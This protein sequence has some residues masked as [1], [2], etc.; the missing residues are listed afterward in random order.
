MKNF[1]HR[2]V[3]FHYFISYGVIILLACLMFGL[4][5]FV[6][7]INEITKVNLIASQSKLD[8]AAADLEMHLNIF[9]EISYNIS[10]EAYFKPSFFKR[11]K[12]YEIDLLKSLMK[13]GN[14]SPLIDDFFLYYKEDAILFK[15]NGTTSSPEVYFDF[16]LGIKDWWN[17]WDQMNNSQSSVL[18]RYDN[19]SSGLIFV[20]YPIDIVV[21]NSSPCKALVVFLIRENTLR[22]RITSLFG[23]SNSSMVLY[24]Q[25]EPLLVLNAD[26]DN[27]PVIPLNHFE[28]SMLS[29]D[30]SI[31]ISDVIYSPLR[32]VM[33]QSDIR[34]NIL[35]KTYR[36][37]LYV[38]MGIIIVVLCVVGAYLAFSNY[39]PIKKLHSQVH[40]EVETTNTGD[41]LKSIEIMFN[42]IKKEEVHSQQIIKQQLDSLKHQ[43]VDIIL[44]G[45]LNPAVQSKALEMGII[46]EGPNYCVLAIN[47]NSSALTILQDDSIWDVLESTSLCNISLYSGNIDSDNC[48]S[49]LMDLLRDPLARDDGVKAI[50]NAFENN[51]LFPNIGVSGIFRNTNDITSALCEAHSALQSSW[52][53]DIPVVY[54]EKLD[55]ADDQPW[56]GKIWSKKM[57]QA[58][59]SHTMNDSLCIIDEIVEYLTIQRQSLVYQRFI[60][61][62]IQAVFMKTAQEFRLDIRQESISAILKAQTPDDFGNHARLVIKY[63]FK[64]IENPQHAEDIVANQIIHYIHEH[65][66]DYDMSLELLSNKFGCSVSKLS[67]II[68]EYIG[69]SFRS[70][71]I[72]LRMEKAMEMLQGDMTV[73]EIASYVGYGSISHFTKTFRTYFGN[74]PSY[75]RTTSC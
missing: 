16:N 40:Y 46:I 73:A 51:A 41:E 28:V 66:C 67:H 18:L 38:A 30:P 70:Y 29:G 1:K 52:Q 55:G 71:L 42:H 74:K 6:S 36:R 43:M 60:Y 39:K 49:I 14:Y 19:K 21:S 45:G 17:L 53:L 15:S 5:V 68:K 10:F 27:Q 22:T 9:Q 12:Y 44:G 59:K 32:L 13:Y 31:L 11:N 23:L 65:S 69:D 7:S 4:I 50:L 33:S 34:D 25:N 2:S 3:L 57:M 20:V 63:L 61:S 56:H 24:Y 48:F 8:T 72:S 58:L 26:I 54:Y 75:Y 47:L 64:Y 62:D 37:S 35:L